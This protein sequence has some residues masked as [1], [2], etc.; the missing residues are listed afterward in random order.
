MSIVSN[1]EILA[2]LDIS[3]GYFEITAA[4]NVL[5]LA[6]DGGTVTDIEC[7]DGSYEGTGLAVELQSKIDTAFAI[8]STVTY[9]IRKFTIDVG[10]EHTVAYTHLGSDAGLTFGFDLDEAAAQTITS[11]NEA[12]DPTAIIETLRDSVESWV[13]GYCRRFFER[14]T[15]SEKYS[16]RKIINLNQYPITDITRVAIATDDAVRICNTSKYTTATVAVTSTGIV[17]TKDGTA[18]STITFADYATMTTL[19]AAVN[20]LGSGWSGVA[21]TAYASHKSSELLERFGASCINGDW[22]YL[23][24]PDDGVNDYEV[25]P[26]KGQIE[27]S[28]FGSI[29]YVDYTAGY[30][31]TDMP[32]SLK[33]C[34]EILTKD[35]FDRRAQEQFGVASYHLGDIGLTLEKTPLPAKVKDILDG[36]RRYL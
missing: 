32:E 22:A 1:S 27:L 26:D 25:W 35:V 13:Q 18:D 12:G 17:L 20:D 14:K 10:T 29:V 24:I 3:K 2:F 4:N 9:A 34:I 11:D 33:M 21:E 28:R 8:L 6:Y 31:S 5:K 19:I 7:A 36:Y 23:K 30:S 15:Y 16:G